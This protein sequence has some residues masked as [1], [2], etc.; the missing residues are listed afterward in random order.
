MGAV[1]PRSSVGG[2]PSSDASDLS[3]CRSPPNCLEQCLARPG[4]VLVF[5]FGLVR[6]WSG[7]AAPVIAEALA[8]ASVIE[9]ANNSADFEIVGADAARAVELTDLA[10]VKGRFAFDLPADGSLITNRVEAIARQYDLA[11]DTSAAREASPRRGL[12]HLMQYADFC[13]QRCVLQ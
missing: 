3:M 6:L 10:A 13:W 7:D 9:S 4:E 11:H 2:W 8:D 5:D 12:I 1:P